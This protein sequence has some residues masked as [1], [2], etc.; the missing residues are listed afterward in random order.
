MKTIAKTALHLPGRTFVRDTFTNGL[1]EI[2]HQ[3]LTPIDPPPNDVETLMSEC[4]DHEAKQ[5]EEIRMSFIESEVEKQMA[6]IDAAFEAKREEIAHTPVRSGGM[7]SGVVDLAQAV[8]PTGPKIVRE[9]DFSIQ[10]S[11][12]TYD[13]ET[14]IHTTD[15]KFTLSIEERAYTAIPEGRVPWREGNRNIA[16]EPTHPTYESALQSA[17]H[18]LATTAR[19]NERPSS[20]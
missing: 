12:V 3:T 4:L 18:H 16:W 10:A 9:L 7:C 14:C 17:M 13:E 2:V 8:L 19:P 6:K 15:G 5:R 20:H 1:G 11:V